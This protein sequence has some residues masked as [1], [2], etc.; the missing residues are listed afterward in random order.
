MTIGNRNHT[1][2]P[3]PRDDTL[4][5][6]LGTV[7]DAMER[8]V[9]TIGADWPADQA[10]RELERRGVSGGPVVDHGRVVGVLTLRDLLRMAAPDA[11]R[12]LATGP[13]LRH[14]RAL[15]RF[16]VAQ[17]MRE[18]VVTARADW[19][20]TLAV[21]TMHDEGVNRLPVVDAHGA[22]IGILARDDVLRAIA[23][24]AG[25]AE[26]APAPVRASQIPPD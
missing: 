24:R 22:P 20:L 1:S 11:P 10:A 13:F 12:A 8:A 15:A 2:R 16:T 26:G 3:G 9:V 21:L 23:R 14:E 25:H 6:A 19:P 17:V 4:E 5:R 7:G 18:R